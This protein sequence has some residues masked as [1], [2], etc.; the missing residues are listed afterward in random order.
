MSDATSHDAKDGAGPPSTARRDQLISIER[1]VQSLW[2]RHRVFSADADRSPRDPSS[3]YFATFPYPYMNGALHLGH[4]FTLAKVDYACGYQRLKGKNVL[5]PF[6]FHCTGMPIAASADKVKREIQ[7][8]GNPPN[9]PKEDD[10]G[11]VDGEGEAE[12]SKEE[13]K[14]G[15]KKAP[16]AADGKASNEE[17]QTDEQRRSER[18]DVEHHHQEALEGLSSSTTGAKRKEEASAEEMERLAATAATAPIAEEAATKA[19]KKRKVGISHTAHTTSRHPSTNTA[20][21]QP[22]SFCPDASY[23]TVLSS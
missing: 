8:Y 21:R 3:K 11:E 5:F 17:G 13:K 20:S 23:L 6:G 18:K 12:E 4:A 22:P 10:E 7:L 19:D 9:F 15:K 16:P 14:E 1:A 2:K